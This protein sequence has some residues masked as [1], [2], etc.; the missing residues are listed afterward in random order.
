MNRKLL[1][2]LIAAPAVVFLFHAAISASPGGEPKKGKSK[3]EASKTDAKAAKGKSVATYSE[4]PALAKEASGPEVE[5]SKKKAFDAKVEALRVDMKSYE[6]IDVQKDWKAWANPWQI[7]K[8]QPELAEMIQTSLMDQVKEANI[9]EFNKEKMFSRCPS[10]YSYLMAKADPDA[11]ELG[12]LTK[13]Y[14]TAR[15]GCH[16]TIIGVFTVDQD[17]GTIAMLISENMG[18]TNVDNW[19]KIRSEV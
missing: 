17:R 6:K 19:L 4:E 16:T 7:K 1:L 2:S 15:E 5:A 10:G 9:F 8:E 3:S 12:S 11:E 13:G 18:Y 14:V